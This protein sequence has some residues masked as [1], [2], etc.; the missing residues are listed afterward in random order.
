MKEAF[1]KDLTVNYQ[2]SNE[3]PVIDNLLVTA[4]CSSNKQSHLSTVQNQTLIKVG[5]KSHIGYYHKVKKNS[6]FFLLC[7][8]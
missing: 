2:K 4:P 8:S 7:T 5:L 1:D 3:R 6:I